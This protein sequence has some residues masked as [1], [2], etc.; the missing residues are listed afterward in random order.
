M[1][2]TIENELDEPKTVPATPTSKVVTPPGGDNAAAEPLGSLAAVSTA[3]EPPTEA[4]PN[5]DT[6]VAKA[7]RLLSEDPAATLSPPLFLALG[8]KIYDIR[9]GDMPAVPFNELRAEVQ[10]RFAVHGLTLAR[11]YQGSYAPSP[12]E[13]AYTTYCAERGWLAFNGEVLPTFANAKP[14]LKEAWDRAARSVL[15]TF[16]TVEHFGTEPQWLF[17]KGDKVRHKKSGA[18][19]TI[20]A[21]Q[22]AGFVIEANTALAYGYSA[23]GD[24]LVWVRPAVEMEDRFELVPA[25]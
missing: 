1:G 18:E 22:V 13:V 15:D 9:H 8:R 24:A 10:D 20:V 2:Q 17:K 7:L 23:P 25:E 14:E 4:Q 21:A 6:L 12:G 19:Y 5:L 16:K 11:T 3:A